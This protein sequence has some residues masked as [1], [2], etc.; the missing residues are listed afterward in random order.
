LRKIIH[1]DEW[2]GF[3]L[4]IV[5]LILHVM[6]SN[7]QLSSHKVATDLYE[8]SISENQ[9]SGLSVHLSIRSID[10][11]RVSYTLVSRSW[12]T[13]FDYRLLRLPDAEI[14]LTLN[15]AYSTSQLT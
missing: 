10:V 6:Y 13:D 7:I 2:D 12:L 5:S 9:R 8:V 4:L 11:G 1:L 15:E 14:G 3:K